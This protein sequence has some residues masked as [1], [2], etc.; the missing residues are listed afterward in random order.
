LRDAHG[1]EDDGEL[2][3]LTDDRRLTRDLSSK[4]VGRQ[5]GARED[6]EL[7]TADEADERVDGRDA[8]LD[9][10]FRFTTRDRVDGRAA[11]GQTLVRHH[12]WQPVDG[13]AGAVEAA[14]DHLTRDTQSRDVLDQADGSAGQVDARGLLEHLKDRVLLRHFDDLTAAF[15]AVAVDDL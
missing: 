12:W 13:R 11:D 2:G 8:G 7:L 10:L 1:R 14:T 3:V 15:A 6:R 4:L 9:E 5:T